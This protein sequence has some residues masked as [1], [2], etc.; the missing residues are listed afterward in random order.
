MPP[1][2]K[3]TDSKLHAAGQII[4]GG[5]YVNVTP[6]GPALDPD[7]FEAGILARMEKTYPG[8]A[9]AGMALCVSMALDHGGAGDTFFAV[10]YLRV[11]N[12]LARR[13]LTSATVD[14]SALA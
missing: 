5:I 13:V 6:H 14:A 4:A 7:E 10:A 2:H 8:D 9:A 1:L 12:E 3:F 11:A